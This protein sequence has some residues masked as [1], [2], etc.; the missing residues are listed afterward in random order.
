MRIPHIYLLKSESEVRDSGIHYDSILF[1]GDMS[2]RGDYLCSYFFFMDHIFDDTHE[3][4][5]GST[6][7]PSPSHT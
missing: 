1:F 5:F 2:V 3:I 6:K 4:A 7:Q